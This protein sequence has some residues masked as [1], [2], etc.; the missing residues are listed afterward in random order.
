[1][2]E[3]RIEEP[4]PVVSRQ[5]WLPLILGVGALLIVAFTLGLGWTSAGLGEPGDDPQPVL[6]EVL[7]EGLGDDQSPADAASP[8]VRFAPGEPL[9]AHQV[10]ALAE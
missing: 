4:V 10:R 3:I 9:V 5:S 6:G 8:L 1:M 2:H 7:G